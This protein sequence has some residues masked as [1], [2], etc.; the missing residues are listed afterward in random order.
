MPTVISLYTGAGGLDW[1]LEAAGFRTS[2]CIEIDAQCVRTLRH[3]RDWSVIDRDITTVPTEEML[4]AAGLRPGQVDLV[5]G[6]PP[7]Q[8]FSKS[9]YWSSG[10]TKRLDDP[11]ANTLG[12]YMRVVEDSLPRAFLLE[13]VQGLAYKGKDEGFLYLQQRIEEINKRKRV[14][15]SFEARVLNAADFGAPQIRERIFIIGSREGT[16]FQFPAPRFAN[17]NLEAPQGSVFNLPAYRNAW[18]AIGDLNDV[19]HGKELDVRGKWGGLLPSIPE[20]ENYLW[21]T[22]RGGGTPIFRWRSRYWSFLLKLA[23]ARPSWTIQAQPGSAIGPFHW[24]NRRL[25]PREMARLQTFPDSVEILGGITAIQRQLG[26]AVPSAVAEL[27]GLEIR[28]QFFGEDV[29][30]RNLSL[31]PPTRTCPNPEPITEVPTSYRSVKWGSYRKNTAAA[32]QAG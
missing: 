7:C 29:D 18:D 10:D 5:A 19:E 3:N 31:I 2:A 21:H 4:E 24:K 11:R 30:S 28:K 15:Y 16:R 26:N 14:N 23:K 6:G 17:P 22:E 25:S 32:G 27:L 8:P 1:G 9:A 13:N 12:E 20:G